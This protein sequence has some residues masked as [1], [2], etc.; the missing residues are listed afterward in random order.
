MLKGGC[1]TS[2]DLKRALELFEVGSDAGDKLNCANLGN[3][4]LN[5]LGV[6]L[7]RDCAVRLLKQTSHDGLTWRLLQL[8]WLPP[9]QP[10]WNHSAGRASLCAPPL[11]LTTISPRPV[12]AQA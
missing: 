4:Y 1:G 3:T 7:D 6:P 12:R 2:K 8:G 9:S 11:P 5:G 10:L